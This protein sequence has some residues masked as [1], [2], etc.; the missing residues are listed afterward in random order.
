MDRRIIKTE[1]AI[2]KA[3]FDLLVERKTS[4]ISISDIARKADI[5]RKTFYLHYDSVDQVLSDYLDERMV[6]IDSLLEK[7][8]Y[9]DN[10]FDVETIYMITEET[11]RNDDIK[12]LKLIA[13][14]SAYDELWLRIQMKISEAAVKLNR[15]NLRG[16]DEALK[17]ASEYF[18]SG[19]IN[20]Y[21]KWLNGDYD[22]DLHEIVEQVSMIAHYGLKQLIITGEASEEA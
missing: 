1:K 21:R 4:R 20:V 16:T 22:A 17:I 9:F 13:G 10:P 14:N 6:Y 5:D 18:S 15:S 11:Q 7:Y 3:Y 8:H 19:V 2:R 12:Y